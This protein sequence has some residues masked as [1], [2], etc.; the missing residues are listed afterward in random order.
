MNAL[1]VWFSPYL[2]IWGVSVS[3]PTAGYPCAEQRNPV[4][5]AAQSPREWL[6]MSGGRD[7]APWACRWGRAWGRRGNGDLV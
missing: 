1:F 2:A 6:L 4:M 5:I 3:S 7:G